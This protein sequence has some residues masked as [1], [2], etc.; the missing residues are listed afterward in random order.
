MEK[1]KLTTSWGEQLYVLTASSI[2]EAIDMF[3][4]VKN[5]PVEVIKKLFLVKKV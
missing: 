3:A 5:L 1:Y 4:M 2:E